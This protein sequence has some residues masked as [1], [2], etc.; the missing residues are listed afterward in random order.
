MNTDLSLYLTEINSKI[1]LEIEL[2]D[3]GEKEPFELALFLNQLT[4][5]VKNY[6]EIL[7]QPMLK[8]IGKFE[9]NDSC[10]K[11]GYK[12]EIH[13]SGKYD[14]KHDSVW[15]E[16]S[17]SLKNREEQ[18][19]IQYAIKNSNKFYFENN[20]GISEPMLN[21]KGE[22]VSLS[23]IFDKDGNIKDKNKMPKTL[24]DLNGDEIP[25]AIYNANKESYKIS[26][27]KNNNNKKK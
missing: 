17:S 1:E 11:N 12:F 5:N 14:Y 22:L 25:M 8:E 10:T 24:F 7:I 19:K 18:M 3:N 16:R 6:R 4:E 20:I 13:K 2:I 27:I 23:E 21:E 26:K 15:Q 9:K